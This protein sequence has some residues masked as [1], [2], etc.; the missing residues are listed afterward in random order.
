VLE[1]IIVSL[2]SWEYLVDFIVSQP[3]YN[4]GGHL[5][6]LGRPWLAITDA[7]TS[8]RSEDMMIAHGDSIKKFNLY[9]PAKYLIELEYT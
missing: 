5:L 9:P 7:F 8:C 1:D 6:I 4:L 2:Y 3:K